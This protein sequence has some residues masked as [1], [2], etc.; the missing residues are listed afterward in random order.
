MGSENMPKIEKTKEKKNK[1]KKKK[2]H[3]FL[4]I[5][6]WTFLIFFLL[7]VGLF[8][9]V[10]ASINSGA[11]ALSKADFEINKFT[12]YIYDING[13]E[14]T[15]VNSGENRTYVS[16]S[17]VSPY[18]PKAFISIEDERFETHKGIDVKRTTAATIKF[19]M[20]KLFKVGEA[21]FG[22]STI[23]QQVIKKVTGEDDRSALRKARE[24]VRAIQ[25]EQWLSKDEIIE[26]YMNLIYLGEG[27]YGVEAASYTYFD[28]SASDL[29]IAE[30]ALIG[31]LAQAPEGY[32]PFKY[33]EKAKQRQLLVL[34]KMYELR[35]Y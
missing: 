9:G 5:I 14:Y 6:L 3:I 22:G 1:I 12:T 4:K 16:I 29:S 32:N 28:K 13:N 20:N 21:D 25:L 19:I 18:L 30:C 23:T 2:K 7:V 24:I 17:E 35:L 31:G 10:I 33:P 26:L 11:G 15:T 8:A 34:N 27:S